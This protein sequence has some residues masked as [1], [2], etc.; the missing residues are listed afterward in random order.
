M[1]K[2]VK[3]EFRTY[4]KKLNMDSKMPKKDK[5]EFKDVKKR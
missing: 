2:E 4:Q 1:S 3:N 5:Y